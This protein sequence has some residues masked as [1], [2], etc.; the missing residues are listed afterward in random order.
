MKRQKAKKLKKEAEQ[1]IKKAEKEAR[2]KIHAAK[3]KVEHE[4]EKHDEKI[5]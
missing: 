5:I 2:E 3:A 4:K 1:K